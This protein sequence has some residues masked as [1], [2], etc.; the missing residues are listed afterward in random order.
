M[1]AHEIETSV[2]LGYVSARHRPC[3]LH[4]RRRVD[5]C[6]L[7]RVAI[8]AGSRPR[9]LLRA[10]CG[11]DGQCCARCD[12]QL[13]RPLGAPEPQALVAWRSAA[14]ARL[15]DPELF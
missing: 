5:A 10:T 7:E 12:H 13:A 2:A 11:V 14:S 4:L 15:G 9:A 3:S 8:A 6:F 1:S